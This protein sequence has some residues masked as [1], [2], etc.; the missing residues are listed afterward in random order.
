MIDISNLKIQSENIG[1]EYIKSIIS[2]KVCLGNNSLLGE[3]MIK[4]RLCSKCCSK[5]IFYP[6]VLTITN[7]KSL[8]LL[9]FEKVFIK[10]YWINFFS[11]KYVMN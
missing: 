5:F 7:I 4:N 2:E 11:L 10:V 1:K 3:K 9:Q 6:T 8:V